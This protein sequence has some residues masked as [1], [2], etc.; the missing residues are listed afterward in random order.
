MCNLYSMTSNQQA[1]AALARILKPVTTNLPL[2]EY[3]GGNGF[4]PI[5]RNTLEGR[6]L[7]MCRWGMPSP[8]SALKGKNYDS[9][10]TNIRY[11]TKPYWKPWL[12]DISARCLVPFTSFSEPDQASGSNVIHWFAETAER[13]LMFFAGIW[14]PAV[15]SVRLVR[16]G[17]TTNDLY[18]F[19]TTDA[20][21]EVKAIHPKAMPVILRSEEERE[22]WMTGTW[23]EVQHLQRPLPDGSLTVVATGRRKDG[24]H[25]D[26]TAESVAPVAPAQGDLF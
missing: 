18:G 15:T 2:F 24:A 11:T 10:V 21:A 25:L 14:A 16:E 3:I 8:E 4:G 17:P 6:E 7:A 9:G 23:E 22:L 26:E 1:I 12:T 20:N 13:P 19:L 5:V